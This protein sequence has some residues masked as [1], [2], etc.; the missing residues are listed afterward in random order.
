LSRIQALA[1]VGSKS[2]DTGDYAFTDSAS[3]DAA[4][5]DSWSQWRLTLGLASGF[6][7]LGCCLISQLVAA[8]AKKSKLKLNKHYSR[9]KY[10]KD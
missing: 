9:K 8:E 7:V 2:S 3:I 4:S 6:S 10:E 1:Q 5:Q